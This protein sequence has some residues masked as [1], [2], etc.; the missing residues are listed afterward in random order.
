MDQCTV[1]I[2]CF[3]HLLICRFDGIHFSLKSDL[4]IYHIREHVI[5]FRYLDGTKPYNQFLIK[6]SQIEPLS[7][8]ISLLLIQ[9]HCIPSAHYF[10]SQIL[11][12]PKLTI[13]STHRKK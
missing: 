1:Q 10:S 9:I 7:Y 11:R 4:L 2:L 12:G 3:N 5:L 8:A 6:L 13:P